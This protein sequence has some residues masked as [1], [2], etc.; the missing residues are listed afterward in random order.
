MIP[1][2]TWLLPPAPYE[3]GQETSRWYQLNSCPFDTL[4][5]P[6]AQKQTM[7]VCLET[8]PLRNNTSMAW[9][10]I[11]P[12]AALCPDLPGLQQVSPRTLTGM[13]GYHGLWQNDHVGLDLCLV[14][15]LIQEG[16]MPTDKPKFTLVIPC[17]YIHCLSLSQSWCRQTLSYL[18]LLDFFFSFR[19]AVFS[20]KQEYVLLVNTVAVSL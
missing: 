17:T 11:P 18:L 10:A 8:L 7:P 5:I 3:R 14:W 4:L 2:R 19:K 16:Q 13:A 20:K 6:L 12:V 1:W 15:K 9:A